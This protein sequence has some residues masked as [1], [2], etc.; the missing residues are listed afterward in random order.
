[1]RHWEITKVP[2][3]ATRHWRISCLR[4]RKWHPQWNRWNPPTLWAMELLKSLDSHQILHAILEQILYFSFEQSKKE[5]RIYQSTQRVSNMNPL[6]NEKIH[7]RSSYITQHCD[8]LYDMTESVGPNIS[9]NGSM[10]QLKVAR[11][12]VTQ[13]GIRTRQLRPPISSPVQKLKISN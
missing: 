6:F 1:M 9:R 2:T 13:E 4:W 7:P 8:S 11:S 5:L 10:R 12:R 3:R